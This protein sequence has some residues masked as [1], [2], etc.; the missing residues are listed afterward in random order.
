LTVRVTNVLDHY[1]VSANVKLNQAVDL[2]DTSKV[3]ARDVKLTASS[4]DKS[5]EYSGKKT[6]Q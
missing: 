4:G 5:V 6:N 3:V 1:A 2:A